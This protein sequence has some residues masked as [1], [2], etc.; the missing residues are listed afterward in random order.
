MFSFNNPYGACPKCTGLGMK[1]EI[2]PD[3]IIPN[4]GLS[5]LQGAVKA[6]RLELLGRRQHCPDVF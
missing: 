3:R 6:R 4:R 2:D 1:L 5:I